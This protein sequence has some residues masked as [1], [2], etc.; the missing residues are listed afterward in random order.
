MNFQQLVCVT[1]TTFYDIFLNV[2][3]A[4]V[5]SYH[6]SCCR[7]FLSVRTAFFCLEVA[8]Q[9]PRLN[10]NEKT[11]LIHKCDLKSLLISCFFLQRSIHCQFI[12]FIVVI[13]NCLPF[14]VFHTRNCAIKPRL[15]EFSWN[16]K[17]KMF[18]VV[19]LLSNKVQKMQSVDNRWLL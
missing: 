17:Q 14:L 15:Q 1:F 4:V 13:E 2:F 19:I 3:E 9:H 5:W 12:F 8:V 11:C 7:H 10:T 6:H 16:Q 18:Q